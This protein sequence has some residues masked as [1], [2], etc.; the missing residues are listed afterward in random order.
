MAN[1]AANVDVAVSGKAYAGPTGTTAP[2]TAVI[3]LNAGFGDLGWV[4]EDGMTESYSDDRSEIRGNDGTVLRTVI[5]GSAA[6]LQFTLLESKAAVLETYHPGSTVETDGSTGYKI[7]VVAPQGTTQ[8]FVYDVIDGDTH[9]RIYVPTGEVTERGDIT[10]T[11]TGAISYPVT[12]S[13]YPDTNGV[14]LTKFS[15]SAAWA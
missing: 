7:D 9:L 3:A 5:S 6:T 1:D 13:C 14:L 8:S 2:T 15:D 4:G 10:Y 11:N 12:I